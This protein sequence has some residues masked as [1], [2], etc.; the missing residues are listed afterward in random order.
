MPTEG[1][2]EGGR[3]AMYGGESLGGGY[4]VRVA[5]QDRAQDSSF[6]KTGRRDRKRRGGSAQSRGTLRCACAMPIPSQVRPKGRKGVETG[7]AAPKGSTQTS[8]LRRAYGE[9]TVQ[10]TNAPTRAGAA[11]KAE[12]G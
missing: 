1:F 4:S 5:Q 9:G 7:R 10:T 3:Q 6:F 8:R 2:L 12:V 11:A